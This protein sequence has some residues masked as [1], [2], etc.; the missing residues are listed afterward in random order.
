MYGI[1]AQILADCGVG[2]MKLMSAPKRFHG[3]GGFGL[4]VV[5]YIHE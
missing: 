3:L 5:D 1:G 2:R 4:E